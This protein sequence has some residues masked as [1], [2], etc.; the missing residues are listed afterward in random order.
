MTM[1]RKQLHHRGLFWILVFSVASIVLVFYAFRGSLLWLSSLDGRPFI[2]RTM[3]S[4]AFLEQSTLQE[5]R[6][7]KQKSIPSSNTITTIRSTHHQ[8][9]T[10][11]TTTTTATL[12]DPRYNRTLT[13]LIPLR[14]ELC[15]HLMILADAYIMKRYVERHIVG[16]SIQLL[17]QHEV[18]WKWKRAYRDLKACFPNFRDFEFS[19]GRHDTKHGFAAIQKQQQTWL[20]TNASLLWNIKSLEQIDYLKSLLDQQ[21]QATQQQQQQSHGGRAA[22]QTVVPLGNNSH[23]SLPYLTS[24]TFMKYPST[25]QDS[26]L[27][28]ELRDWLQINTTLPQCCRSRAE[29]DEVVFHFRNFVTEVQLASTRNLHK[30]FEL[31]P[32]ET[33]Q[34]LFGS[35]HY[36]YGNHT[37]KRKMAL[38]SRF[39]NTATPFVKTL[40]GDGWTVRR[41]KGQSGVQDFCFALSAQRELVGVR[42]STYA[43][44]AGF[45]GNATKVRLY[46]VARNP[47]NPDVL[48]LWKQTR[49]DTLT[50]AL[51]GER[52][53]WLEKYA[54]QQDM[55]T[56]SL[57]AQAVALIEKQ[58]KKAI[59]F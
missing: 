57:K 49:I 11:T 54:S 30:F 32:N 20:G 2:P 34:Y 53:F 35:N 47:Q 45:L 42:K 5:K 18:Y 22:N 10:T 38:I 19:A 21:A 24:D 3:G 39:P 13:L 55:T 25:L 12:A 40:Q 37:L 27:Y 26:V 48:G 50:A 31:S 7:A 51:L 8:V 41:I 15:N 59:A 28:H 4:W 58:E 44:W 46:K 23:Y 43:Q 36:R 6:R 52:S 1:R 33:A 14:G 9:A 17:G 56:E 16:L 29:A